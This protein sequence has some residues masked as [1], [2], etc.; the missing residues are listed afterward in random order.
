MICLSES[1]AHRVAVKR[2][3]NSLFSACAV[4]IKLLSSLCP[5]SKKAERCFAAG[6]GMT[7]H[8]FRVEFWAET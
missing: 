7:L 2:P 3:S 5:G 8:P 4:E 1:S 6:E